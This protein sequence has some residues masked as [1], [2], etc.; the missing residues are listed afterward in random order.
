MLLHRDAVKDNVPADLESSANVQGKG[1]QGR[2]EAVDNNRR[3]D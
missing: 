3:S 1:L 2:S